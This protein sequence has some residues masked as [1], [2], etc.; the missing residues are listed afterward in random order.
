[1]IKKY[2]KET[3]KYLLR[4]YPVIRTY[5][6]RV[7]A[8]YEMSNEELKKRNEERFL[9]IFRRAYDKSPFYHRL[10]TEAGIKKEDIKCLEDIKKLPVIT[11]DMVK[12]HA[13]EMLTVPKWQVMAG[14]TS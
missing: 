6:K 5:I 2:L 13:S 7:D 14:H 9:Y 12:K 11:K 10:Y 3:A 8:M 1:M 4:C